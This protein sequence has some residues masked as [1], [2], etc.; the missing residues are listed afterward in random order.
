MTGSVNVFVVCLF[1][2]F[3]KKQEKSTVILALAS[4]RTA[5]AYDLW[6]PLLSTVFMYELWFCFIFLY[7]NSEI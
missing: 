4:L 5:E 3:S 2:L 6:A 7:D 1:V